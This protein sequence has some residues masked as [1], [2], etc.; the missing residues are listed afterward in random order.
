MILIFLFFSFIFHVLF[1]QR[2]ADEERSRRT[3][4]KNKG[5][6]SR[7]AGKETVWLALKST[8]FRPQTLAGNYQLEEQ[9]MMRAKKLQLKSPISPL[10]LTLHKASIINWV[11]TLYGGQFTISTQLIILNYPVWSI[12]V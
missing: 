2:Q 6:D 1:F 8:N 3:D 7:S 10:I 4:D 12:L 5:M 9:I 11:G